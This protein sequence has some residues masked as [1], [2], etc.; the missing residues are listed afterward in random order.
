MEIIRKKICLDN[1]KSHICGAL[2][3]CGSA[4]PDSGNFGGF[5]Y[6]ATGI[7]VGG[8]DGSPS[9]NLIRANEMM[10]RY[11]TLLEILRNSI[12]LKHSKNLSCNDSSHSYYNKFYNDFDFNGTTD[13]FLFNN[14]INVL[15]ES[16]FTYNNNYY[17]YNGSEDINVDYVILISDKDIET[18]EKYNGINFVNEVHNIIFNGDTRFNQT[19][20]IPIN[21][22]LTNS[23]DDIGLMSLYEYE[24]EEDTFPKTYVGTELQPNIAT[25]S[26]DKR[27]RLESRLK[28]LRDKTYMQDDNGQTLPGIF[29]VDNSFYQAKLVEV[30]EE[31]ITRRYWEI[32]STGGTNLS[33]G[34]GEDIGPGVEKYRTQTVYGTLEK[35]LSR[36]PASVGDTY[37]FLVK[38]NNSESNPA[39]I[40]YSV[41]V[42]YNKDAYEFEDT[43]TYTGD[44][45]ISID[46]SENGYIEFTYV[47][48]AIFSDDT[49]TNYTGGTIY[50]EKYAYNTKV[51][52]KIDL[53]GFSGVSY[54]YNS[55]DFDGAKEEIINN[56]FNL[57]KMANTSHINKMTT[58]D[59]WKIDGTVYDSPIIKEDYLMGISMIGP[60]DIDVEIN[61]GNAAAFES[62]FRLSECNSFDDI[63][64]NGNNGFFNIE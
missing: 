54:W 11:N 56:D 20:F 14:S 52:G 36:T 53:D 28:T 35:E 19:P 16:D 22:L 12:H 50:N 45:I 58:G 44:M 26:D 7:T 15:Y 29:T 4:K 18:Y 32:I 8:W 63:A 2:P 61:R 23:I 39:R 38:Y 46:T 60:T 33:C 41:G 47:L 31:G 43:I 55:I 6:D 17:T 3:Y 10:R 25:F 51:E 1:F 30:T 27:P 24:D 42:V 59:V 57:T 48:G 64:T 40:P 9:E 62:H 49:Y 21:V 5:V 37:Y 13:D 34:D